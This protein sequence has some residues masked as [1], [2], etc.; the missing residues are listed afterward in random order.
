MGVCTDYYI[1]TGWF[2][3][4]CFWWVL[5]SAIGDTTSILV[6]VYECGR[7]TASHY[8]DIINEQSINSHICKIHTKPSHWRL[9]KLSIVNSPCIHTQE[10]NTFLSI[11]FSV[12][13]IY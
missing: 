4:F 5:G 12:K 7:P 2:N 10:T 8:I 9:K 1:L 13:I 11:H 6:S 3:A